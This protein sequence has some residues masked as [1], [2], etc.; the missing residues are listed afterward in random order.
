MGDFFENVKTTMTK[1]LKKAG[2]AITKMVL[3]IVL[4]ILIAVIIVSGLVYELTRQ[5]GSYKEGDMSNVPYAST[6]YTADVT[7]DENGKITTSMTAQELWDEMIKNNSRVDEYLDGPEDLLKLM[8]AEII[9]N[10]PDTRA[11]P[12]EEIDWDTLNKNI[13]SNEVQGIIKFKRAKDDGSTVTMTY[14]DSQTF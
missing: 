6:K 13:D 1:A 10:Y 5:D 4:I 9:T 2:K 8:N 7:I 12:D 14:V 3:P 11:N